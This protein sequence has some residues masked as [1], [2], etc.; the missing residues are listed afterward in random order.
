MFPPGW[1]EGCP[2][3]SSMVDGYDG[4]RV[5]LENH[6]VAVTTVSRAPA[7]KLAAYR[8]RMGWD[9]NWVSSAGS[10]FNFDFGV[11]YT[12]KQ[13]VDGAEHNYRRIEIDPAM[14]PGGGH[15]T[16]P[17]DDGDAHGLS[18]FVLDDGEVYHTYSAYARGMDG[19][20]GMYQWLDRAPL[21]RNESGPWFR[22]HDEYDAS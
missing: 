20:W 5:H 16:E 14:L 17:V 19:L 13:L 15:G 8:Q 3:C 1:T 22:R 2:T 7:D 21:G 10:D 18:T 11:S 12:E 6:D 4:F 9:I